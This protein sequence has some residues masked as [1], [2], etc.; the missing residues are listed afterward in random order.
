MFNF[1]FFVGIVFMIL[2]AMAPSAMAVDYENCTN[3][4]E[5]S[6]SRQLATPVEVQ[7]EAA[8]QEEASKSVPW[9][10]Y[11][12]NFTKS[13][14]EPLWKP[15]FTL[16]SSTWKALGK[17]LWAGS[18]TAQVGIETTGQAFSLV[19]AVAW[20]LKWILYLAPVIL[21]LVLGFAAWTGRLMVVLPFLWTGIKWFVGLFTG[22]LGGGLKLVLSL[23]GKRGP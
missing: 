7:H 4:Y 6:S 15:L 11:Y 21:L 10:T 22:F 12:W 5:E 23:L 9:Y 2:V 16:V 14:T 8:K 19:G 18:E 20:I 3:C 17:L 1:R 13:S